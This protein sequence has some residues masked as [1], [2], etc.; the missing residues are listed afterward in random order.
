[1]KELLENRAAEII[2]EFEVKSGINGLAFELKEKEIYGQKH[3][4]LIAD[5]PSSALGIMGNNM[6]N[7]QIIIN[8]RKTSDNKIYY[9]ARFRYEHKDGGNNGMDVMTA[10][11]SQP[12]RGI[13]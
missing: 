11:G 9:D 6:K 4:E 2:E 5:V 1:M 8:L 13:I 3:Y 12:V 7:V 10:D